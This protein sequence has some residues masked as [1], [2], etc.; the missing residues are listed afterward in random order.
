MNRTR[1]SVLVAG[2]IA[3]GIL[4]ACGGVNRDGSIDSFV[5][6]FEKEGITVDRDCV[7]GVFDQYSDDEL[8]EREG[9]ALSSEVAAACA[10]GGASEEAPAEEAPAEEAPAEEAPEEGS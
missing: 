4:S 8:K 1:V 9:E 6:G 3:A 10:G 7:K 5:E 2:L